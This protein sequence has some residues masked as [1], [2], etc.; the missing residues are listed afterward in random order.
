MIIELDRRY[1]P[2]SGKHIEVPIVRAKYIIF[3]KLIEYI[4]K[5]EKWI[6]LNKKSGEPLGIIQWYGAWWQY[7]F[8]PEDVP[9]V[10]NNGCLDTISQF[11]T[12]MNKKQRSKKNLT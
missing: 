2:S 11:L 8:E 4:G 9:L 6:V 7:V 1:S 3:E 10:F 5:T 12:E